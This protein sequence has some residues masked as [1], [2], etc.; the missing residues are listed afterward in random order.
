MNEIVKI[1]TDQQGR[2]VVSARELY[3]YLGYN[4]SVYSRWSQKNI[5]KNQFAIEGED[6]IGVQLNVEGNETTDYALSIDFSKRLSMLA[7]TEK[8]ENVR[9]YFIECERTA[10]EK[11]KPT[12]L[13]NKEVLLLA[14]EAE[15]RAEV[16][17]QLLLEAKPKVD[18]YNEVTESSDVLDFGSVAKLIN[19]RGFGRNNLF[20]FLRNKKVLMAN[21]S[22]YQSAIDAGYFKIVETR[23]TDKNGDTK[24]NIKTVVFQKGVQY[25]L[26]L[27]KNSGI[28]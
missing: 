1:T 21:N 16:A 6:W 8:G 11:S 17:E 2:Q 5:V 28:E 9:K 14:L 26:K 24:I 20:E 7:R 13:S 18:F 19:K 27:L 12:K 25:I 23:W 22:P 3:E 4:K 15:E 10:I